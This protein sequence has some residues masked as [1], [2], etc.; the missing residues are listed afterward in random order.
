M[1]IAA[2]V[3]P[4]ATPAAPTASPSAAAAPA[5]NGIRSLRLEAGSAART[6]AGADQSFERRE[7][8]ERELDRVQTALLSE[9]ATYGHQLNWLMLSQALLLNAFL[10]VLVLGWSTPLPGKRL[11]LAGLAVFA[12]SVAVLIVLALRGTRDAVMSLHQHRRRLEGALQR[13]FG[14]EPLFASR[15]LVTRAL[16]SLANG[17]LP[18]LMLAGWIA[19]TIYAL[20]APLG[21][22][23]PA[24][25]ARPTATSSTPTA[26]PGP[27]RTARPNAGAASAAVEP[28]TLT[29]ASAPTVRSAPLHPDDEAAAS[30]PQR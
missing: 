14:R 18:A 1:R 9:R 26:R 5:T 25:S 10:V 17:V 7:E 2:T 3:D 23:E 16:A 27:A 29:A 13:D 28:E 19:I 24:P 30:Q 8:L 20:A 4:F 15:A 21:A 12:M 6:A 22:T 11:L